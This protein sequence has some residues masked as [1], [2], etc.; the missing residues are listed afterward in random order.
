VK[1]PKLGESGF[2]DVCIAGIVSGSVKSQGCTYTADIDVN[3]QK[4]IDVIPLPGG[5]NQ[6]KIFPLAA[7]EKKNTKAF[8]TFICNQNGKKVKFSVGFLPGEE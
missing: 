8:V 2:V 4:Y 7:P 5:K 1:S 6:F 3:S